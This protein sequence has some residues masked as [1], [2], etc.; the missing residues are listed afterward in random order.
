MPT[1]PGLGF[2]FA[3]SSVIQEASPITAGHGAG[4]E[5]ALNAHP[6][7]SVHTHYTSTAAQRTN[8]TGSLGNA[9]ADG[10]LLL[11]LCE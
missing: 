1:T 7:G 5:T 2:G 6:V 8:L 11:L 3:C 9:G 4:V 10:L